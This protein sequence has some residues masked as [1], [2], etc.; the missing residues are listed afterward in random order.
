MDEK[1]GPSKTTGAQKKPEKTPSSTKTPTPGPNATPKVTKTEAADKEKGKTAAIEKS[2]EK[3]ELASNQKEIKADPKLIKD[4]FDEVSSQFDQLFPEET[5]GKPPQKPSGKIPKKEPITQSASNE[6]QNGKPSPK[7]PEKPPQA[8][9]EKKFD[10]VIANAD[11]QSEKAKKQDAPLAPK[12][13]GPK[14]KGLT[15]TK[16]Q[17]SKPTLAVKETAR[18]DEEK[19]EKKAYVIPYPKD[20]SKKAPPKPTQKPPRIPIKKKSEKITADRGTPADKAQKKVVPVETKDSKPKTKILQP[21]K[22][23]V[24]KPLPP[25]QETPK[26]RKSAKAEKKNEDQT[27]DRKKP[28]EKIDVKVAKKKSSYKAYILFGSLIVLGIVIALS[29]FGPAQLFK[30]KEASQK[31]TAQKIVKIPLRPQE[32]KPVSVKKKPV[33]P[34]PRSVEKKATAP[35]L[36][37]IEKKVATI[38]KQSVEKSFVPVAIQGKALPSKKQPEKQPEVIKKRKPNLPGEVN[39]F[40]MKWKAAWENTAGATGDIETYMSF[41]S[42]DFSANGLD[43]S[44]WK[45]NKAG[46]NKAKDWIRIGIKNVIILEKSENKHVEVYFLQDYQSSNYTD[47]SGKTLVLKK[48][49]TGWKIIGTKT[50]SR[51]YPY[52]AAYPYSIHM[53]S[54]RSIQPARQTVREHQSMGLQAFW[55][56][57]DLGNKGVWYRVFSGCY[58]NSDA[59]EKTIRT[60]QLKTGKPQRARYANFIGT[61]SSEDSLRKQNQSLS[62]YGYAPY[63]IKDDQGK[64]HLFVGG[65]YKVKNAEKF[66]AELSSKGILSQVVER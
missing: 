66:S 11:T 35:P 65:F 37:P 5:K 36:K 39:S 53:G 9:Q 43:K 58:K 19:I 41:Y 6:R 4:I 54:Y 46:K 48:E 10:K 59:A 40:L 55:V 38:P 18:T 64:F 8:S 24:G 52:S 22:K 20:K 27:V 23:K 26:I 7:A 28:E 32:K 3:K 56:R 57:V 50:A 13:S 25:A 31:L 61:Y 49:K 30:K 62:K 1:K 2:D 16:K 63:F 60:K 12:D 21:T 42:D 29:F 15:E 51:S 34:A 45:H 14:P 44:E 17:V 33:I 47:I